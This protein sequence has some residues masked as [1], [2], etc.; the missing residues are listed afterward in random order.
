MKNVALVTFHTPLSIGAQLQAFALQEAIISAGCNC[1]VINYE[2]HFSNPSRCFSPSR[3]LYSGITDFV[4]TRTIKRQCKRFSDWTSTH[5]RCTD[6]IATYSKLKDEA[7]KFDIFVC[8]SDQIWRMP[9]RPFYF[10]EFTPDSASRVAYAPS[11][12]NINFDVSSKELIKKNLLRFNFISVREND[13]AKFV[14]ELL[15]RE[16]PSVLDPT[17]LWS[18]DY[19]RGYTADP[20]GC[21]PKRFI[22]VFSIQ[23]TIACYRAARKIS[24]RLGIPLVV[25]DAARRLMWHPFL[26]NYFDVGPSEFLQLVDLSD[27]IVT[28]SFHGTAFAVNFNKPF[29]TI[30]RE[31]NEN[32]NSRIM[33][34]ADKMRVFDR[35]ISPGDGVPE[36]VFNELDSEINNRLVNQRRYCRD[37]LTKSLL[38]T[39]RNN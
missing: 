9:F 22:L 23:D 37:I 38:L 33:T 20:G 14:S 16:I 39:D 11:F 28:S 30:C 8:G 32:V 3:R 1:Q 5:L 36:S 21:L 35:L 12:G 27:F 26:K 19:W 17:L 13:G 31:G 2:P 34:L 29:L 4:F 10:L 24:K 7:K 18:A 25:V 6:P 15:G